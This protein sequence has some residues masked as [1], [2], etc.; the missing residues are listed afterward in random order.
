[1]ALLDKLPKNTGNT[2]EILDEKFALFV[3]GTFY[4]NRAGITWFGKYVAPNIDIKTYIVGRGFEKFKDELE[5]DGKVIVIGEV[6]SL[7]EWYLKAH[8]VIA[9]IFDGSGMKTKVAEALMYGKKIIGT[10]EAF[11]GYEEISDIAGR[12]CR[13]AADF[14]EAIESVDEIVTSSFD[15]DLRSIYEEKYSYTA[16]RAR[17][18]R[19]MNA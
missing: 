8:F 9:P 2:S 17:L 3:G 4:A 1:M 18:E 16:S 13:T 10:P 19:I 15:K 6:D 12:V 7:S 5:I 11:T 14:V